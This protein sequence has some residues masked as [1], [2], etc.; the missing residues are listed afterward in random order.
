MIE[1]E[2]TRE[3]YQLDAICKVI[4]QSANAIRVGYDRNGLPLLIVPYGGRLLV[5]NININSTAVNVNELSKLLYNNYAD[6]II[7]DKEDV[8]YLDSIIDEHTINI[9]EILSSTYVVYVNV[10]ESWYGKR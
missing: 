1:L 8:V 4:D 10:E 9:P 6:C 7:I 5:R 2:I 3:H